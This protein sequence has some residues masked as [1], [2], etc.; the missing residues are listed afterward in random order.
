ML[1]A[2]PHPAL[3]ALPHSTARLRCPLGLL[4]LETDGC[5]L[6]RVRMLDSEGDDAEGSALE[7]APAPLLVEARHQLVAWLAGEARSFELPLAPEGTAFQRAV[8][9]ALR[10]IPYGETTS[11]GAI[12]RAIGRPRAVRFS[13]A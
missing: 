12:A 4:A 10:A 8:W 6:T 1:R 9:E 5:A 2:A 13:G 3:P 11:Y 7:A